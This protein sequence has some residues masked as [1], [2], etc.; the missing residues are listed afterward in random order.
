MAGE[1]EDRTRHRGGYRP[2]PPAG[3]NVPRPATV[4][5]VDIELI[6]DLAVDRA[7]T[8]DP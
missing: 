6:D 4:A 7:R 8:A 2:Q 1:D 5:P 3:S